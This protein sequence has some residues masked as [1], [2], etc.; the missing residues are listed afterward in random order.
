MNKKTLPIWSSL[1]KSIIIN[2]EYEHYKGFRYKV[3]KLLLENAETIW[4]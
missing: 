2:G 3:S 4:V 1:A